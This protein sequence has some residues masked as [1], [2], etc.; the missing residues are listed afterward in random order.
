MFTVVIFTLAAALLSDAQR[1]SA[2]KARRAEGVTIPP[3]VGWRGD[4]SE[5]R[6][7]SPGM[8]ERIIVWHGWGDYDSVL[9]DK[10]YWKLWIG[11]DG[12]WSVVCKIDQVGHRRPTFLVRARA[13]GGSGDFD[14]AYAE[15]VSVVSAMVPGW[16]A[17]RY[18]YKNLAQREVEAAQF[19][20]LVEKQ[21]AEAAADIPDEGYYPDLL[22][23]SADV[24]GCQEVDAV[25]SDDGVIVHTSCDGG[26]MHHFRYMLG[27]EAVS[28]LT[29]KA[30]PAQRRANE[31]TIDRVFTAPEYRRQ[32]YARELLDAARS[33]FRRVHHS[34]EL[35]GMGRKW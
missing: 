35:T 34:H 24:R 6:G 33:H 4:G 15:M 1:E 32:G 9:K 29:L 8:P 3:Q 19:A 14:S 16:K 31:A 20:R 18:A 12:S 30:L 21:R 17:P 11:S 13:Q 22:L 10:P 28:G 7:F 5:T 25:I 26:Y 27:G 23:E 2:I